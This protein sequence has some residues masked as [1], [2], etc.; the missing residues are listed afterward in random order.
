[1]K[2]SFTHALDIPLYFQPERVGAALKEV[3]VRYSGEGAQRIETRWF[4]GPDEVE[5]FIWTDSRG[6]VIKQQF[7]VSGAV[8][9][10][11]VLDGLR[12]GVIVEQEMPEAQSPSESVR[13]DQSPLK[14]TVD[15]A[16]SIVPH[17]AAMNEKTKSTLL[18]HLSKPSFDR[19]SAQEIFFRYGHLPDGAKISLFDRLKVSLRRLLS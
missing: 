18:E 10:W 5:I 12:T 14:M 17:V 15:M 11:N 6:G 9:E 4:R 7:N 1:M 13:F 2:T 8:V 16:T 19:L 3:E